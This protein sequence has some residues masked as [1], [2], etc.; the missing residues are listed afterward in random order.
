M[1]AIP[2][3][4]L[5]VKILLWWCGILTTIISFLFGLLLFFGRN[6]VKALSLKFNSFSTGIKSIETLINTN[7][8]DFVIF[9]EK[10]FSDIKIIFRELEIMKK[11]TDKIEDIQI[12]TEKT[13]TMV[14]AQR[15][16]YGKVIKKS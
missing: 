2:E 5:T 16:N 3:G 14:E 15:E 11:Q 4:L 13:I 6:K 12:K 9:R 8:T 1:E 7:Q 10:V